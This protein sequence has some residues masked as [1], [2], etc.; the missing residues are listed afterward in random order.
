MKVKLCHSPV[1]CLQFTRHMI[2]YTCIQAGKHA[3]PNLHPN[4][5]THTVHTHAACPTQQRLISVW[6]LPC[7]L[8]CLCWLA[9]RLRKS[10]RRQHQQRSALTWHA[11]LG[12]FQPPPARSQDADQSKQKES[13]GS[14]LWFMS[15]GAPEK[16][17]L[18]CLNQRGLCRQQPGCEP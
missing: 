12:Y 5:S 2:S 11:C 15:S 13:R 17:L 3:H 16:G 18:R 6:L 8:L 4:T 10:Y 9:P 1:C 7:I 14:W